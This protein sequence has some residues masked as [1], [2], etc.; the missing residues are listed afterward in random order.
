[1]DILTS[2]LSAHVIY[3]YMVLFF[4][5]PWTMN[6]CAQDFTVFVQIQSYGNTVSLVEPPPP[7]VLCRQTGS[8]CFHWPRRV[9]WNQYF[10]DRIRYNVNRHLSVS[11]L[12]DDFIIT[13]GTYFYATSSC[14][15]FYASQIVK[16]ALR[17]AAELFTRSLSVIIVLKLYPVCFGTVRRHSYRCIAPY[18]VMVSSPCLR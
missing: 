2:C 12:L 16:C 6:I 8:D 10:R 3:H 18:V 4:S 7:Y 15:M 11:S 1:M 14:Q 13:H 17:N 9:L 5:K